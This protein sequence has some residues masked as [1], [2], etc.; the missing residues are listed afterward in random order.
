MTTRAEL[1]ALTRSECEKLWHHGFVAGRIAALIEFH[2]ALDGTQAYTWPSHMET[3]LA[4]LEKRWIAESTLK[5]E[6]LAE[7][8]AFRTH[9]QEHRQT[10]AGVEGCRFCV[11]RDAKRLLT[12]ETP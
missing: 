7:I 11:E 9:L 10:E 3:A 5:P 8:E 12:K 1:E 6:A 2:K 4:R